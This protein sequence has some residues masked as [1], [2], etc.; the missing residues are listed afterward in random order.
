MLLS[1]KKALWLV[2]GAM[3]ASHALAAAPETPGAAARAG[4]EPAYAVP[5]ANLAA[6]DT[7]YTIP[8]TSVETI[9]TKGARDYRVMVSWP[10]TKA[11]VTGWPVMYVLDGTSY[12]AMATDILRNQV[13]PF[14][15]PLEAGV[16][17]AVGYH[18]RNRREFDYTPKAPPGPPE[19]R[20]DGTPYPVVEYGGAD[21]F[22]D[23]LETDLKPRI[24]GRFRIDKTRQTLFGHSYGG[25]FVLHT[26][27]TRPQS[28]STYIASS[29]SIWWNNRYIEKEEQAFIKKTTAT[30]LPR[31][32]RLLITV[33][34]DEQ[35]LLQRD[36]RGTQSER[37]NLE[38]RRGRRR[39]VDST[40]EMGERLGGLG[41]RN[42]SVEHRTFEDESH[43]SVAT[44]ALATAVAMAFTLKTEPK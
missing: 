40:K 7:P 18:E 8:R 43:I 24:E 1:L 23:F 3:V 39:M 2:G 9:V 13:C 44:V 33:G 10:E 4:A 37:G 19:M 21:E 16:I 14:P 25:L 32:T 27:F 5:R 20:L 22:L 36:L 35:T 41:P 17:V 31:E 26:L 15:C 30:P 11:P 38:W 6:H 29:P 12:F 34:E 42:M 28:F